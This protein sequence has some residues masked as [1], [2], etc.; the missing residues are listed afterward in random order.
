MQD[1]VHS[2]QCPGGVVHLLA[3][4]GDSAGSLIGG[5]EQQRSGTAGGVVDCLVLAGVRVDADHLGHDAGDFGGR[6]EL[7]LALARLSSEMPHQVLVGVAQQIVAFGSIGT[8]VE[9]IEDGDQLG[10]PVLHLFART[11]LAFVI[12]VGLVDDTL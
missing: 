1:H 8:E 9:I 2:R 12:E 10:E 5:L 4:D 11:E 6:V 3:V 7:P